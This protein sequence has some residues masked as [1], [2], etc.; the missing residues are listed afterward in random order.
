MVIVQIGRI[1]HRHLSELIEA[2]YREILV[3]EFD[4]SVLAHGLQYSVDVHRGEAGGFA[5]IDLGQWEL[6]SIDFRET[7]SP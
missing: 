7:N 1:E 2:G 6:H 5:D 3:A 4:Q